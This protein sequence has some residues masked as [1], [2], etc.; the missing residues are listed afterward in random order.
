[1][2]LSLVAFIVA[3]ALFL[4]GIV[5]AANSQQDRMKDCSVQAEGMAGPALD[6][7]STKKSAASAVMMPQVSVM[8]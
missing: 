6:G 3:G 7:L 5:Q 2:Q 1:M 4:P 8:P